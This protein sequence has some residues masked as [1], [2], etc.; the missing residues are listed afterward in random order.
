MDR[1]NA[2]LLVL[3]SALGGIIGLSIITIEE[4]WKA[5]IRVI[6]GL[7]IY[8]YIWDAIYNIPSQHIRLLIAIPFVFTLVPVIM[9]GLL[10][11][12]A[13]TNR[14]AFNERWEKCFK[15]KADPVRR[16]KG[17]WQLLI[18]FIV[19]LYWGM[20]PDL[21]N[22]EMAIV[23]ALWGLPTIFGLQNFFAKEVQGNNYG[24]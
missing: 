1:S 19:W 13:A 15:K 20:H 21:T 16:K 2:G 6:L 23:I 18:G 9:S 12:D 4:R 7:I 11:Y 3:L 24:Q 8:Y 5:A 22:R 14:E 10:I 17:I